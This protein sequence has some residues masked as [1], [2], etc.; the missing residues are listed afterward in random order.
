M[1][2]GA[3]VPDAT[4]FLIE[5]DLWRFVVRTTNEDGD[6]EIEFRNWPRASSNF[7]DD[8]TTADLGR[9][10]LV[11]GL[12]DGVGDGDARLNGLARFGEPFNC[13][14]SISSLS[15]MGHHSMRRS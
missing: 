8:V 12:G 15:T 2:S 11:C 6:C 9:T 5:P 3:K 14:G 1:K 4:S 10:V 13:D 7:W